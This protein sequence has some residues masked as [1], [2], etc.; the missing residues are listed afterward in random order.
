MEKELLEAGK[1]VNTHGV[2]GEVKIM[3]YCD[4]PGF[5]LNFNTLYI[6]NMPIAV[7]QMRVHG[8]MALTVLEGVNSIND[9]ML[10]KNKLIYFNKAD[11]KLPKGTM[12]INDLIGSLVF[13]IRTQKVIG[14][15]KDVLK[16]PANDVYVV[17]D[18]EREHLIPVC[19]EFVKEIDLENKKITINSIE[20]ML[21]E[22]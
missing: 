10:L 11:I 5:L 21:N 2:A 12:F 9:A 8:T 22:D 13:D 20:G 3:P 7:K 16:L 18:G 6:N 17:N 4:N 14:E 15:I 1:I 19:A